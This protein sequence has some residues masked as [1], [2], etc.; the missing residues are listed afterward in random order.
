VLAI[1]V[2][3]RRGGFQLDVRIETANG[4]AAGTVGAARDGRGSGKAGAGGAGS[5]A[6]ALFGRS[7]CGKSTLVDL[8]AGLVRPDSGHIRI[9]DS[10]LYDSE[11][12]IHVPAE[13]RRVGYVFQDARLFPHYSVRGNLLYG[14]RR[15][16]RDAAAAAAA[17]SADFDRV[18]ELLALGRLL[19]RRPRTL[20]GGERQRVA[21]G[22]ALLARPR[23][24]LLDE[25]LASLDAAR[26]DEV[27]PYLERLRDEAALPMLYVS[28][29]F[30]EVLR[31]AT[32]VALMDRGR[33]LAQGDV[34]AISLHPELRAIVGADAI[35]AVLDGHVDAVDAASG[36]A[37][38]HVAGGSLSVE[39]TGL[40]AGTR[41][42][43]QLLARDL[44]LSLSP[45]RGLS[46]R[47]ALAGRVVDVTADGAHAVLVSVDVGGATVVARVTR[48]A[49]HELAL[50]PALP[51]YVLVKT[52]TLRG[53]VF[54][55]P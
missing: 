37:R 47:N 7:G 32:H 30:D 1:D 14:A 41:V 18:V 45:P 27:L 38:V 54:R 55:G 29:D 15:A 5:A 46:V 52:A 36:L 31:I 25:P 11:R 2:R 16:P 33:C 8:V 48:S 13:R 19:E 4:A 3:K 42:R 17:A 21:I 49:A 28:H 6:I 23:L 20:S 34:A 9:G 12:G 39:D 44:L 24:L 10:V 40:P 26:R 51:L 35:G 50:A 53:H 43:V 22:R